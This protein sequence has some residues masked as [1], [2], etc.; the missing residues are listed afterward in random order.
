MFGKEK[1]ISIVKKITCLKGAFIVLIFFTELGSMALISL[2]IRYMMNSV[3]VNW[4][5]F[6][7]F[8]CV[9]PRTRV[10]FLVT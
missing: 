3:H 6:N 1:P 7:V 2:N 9:P 4:T 10:G 5:L 8:P